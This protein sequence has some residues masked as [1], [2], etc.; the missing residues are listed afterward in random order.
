MPEATKRIYRALLIIFEK[1]R[2]TNA[3]ERSADTYTLQARRDHS[4]RGIS[5]ASDEIRNKACNMG[6][7]LVIE[8]RNAT[9][10]QADDI[11]PL[12]YQ[13]SYW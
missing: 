8:V 3:R 11:L 9:L 12:R 5:T 13:R 4:G 2:R 6:S 1:N 10:L 7:S